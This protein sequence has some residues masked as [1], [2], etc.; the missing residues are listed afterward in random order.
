MDF[1]KYLEAAG[2]YAGTGY[3]FHGHPEWAYATVI[4]LFIINKVYNYLMRNHRKLS[5][6]YTDE[7]GNQRE[8]TF[9]D[10]H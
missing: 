7:N 3:L 2:S 9:S 10:K 8:T 6:K 1:K 5:D 4:T